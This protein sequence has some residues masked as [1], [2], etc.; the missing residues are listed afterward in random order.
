MVDLG[1]NESNNV[2]LRDAAVHGWF[3]FDRGLLYPD[4]V[5]DAHD[6]VADIGCGDGGAAMFCARRGARVLLADVDLPRLD[7]AYHRLDSIAPGRISAHPVQGAPVPLEDG[8]ATR[9]ICT[10]VIEH[11]EDPKFLLAELFRIGRPGALLLLSCPDPRAEAVQQ[12]LAPPA[13]FERPNHIRILPSDELKALAEEAGF[14]IRRASSYGFDWAVWWS[15]FWTTGQE[16][17]ARNE[18]LDHWARAWQGIL[19]S[20]GGPRVQKVMDEVLPKSQVLVCQKP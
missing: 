3:D 2:G 9:I 20:E 5:V 15:L 6:V 17:G 10:E 18:V 14:V 4:F 11:V 8:C 19:D 16:F 1:P 13:Y 7:A 12:K